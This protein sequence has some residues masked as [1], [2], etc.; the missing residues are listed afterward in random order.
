MANIIRIF[1][2]EADLSVKK[3][4][5]SLFSRMTFCWGGFSSC[6]QNLSSNFLS[7]DTINRAPLQG[8]DSFILEKIVPITFKVP[9][10]SNFNFQDGQS[11]LVLGEI[12]VLHQTIFSVIGVS[13]LDYLDKYLPNIGF[14]KPII[15]QLINSVKESDKKQFK[16]FLVDFFKPK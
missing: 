6:T 7:R 16:Q 13:Y 9:M 15:Y 14:S 12:S 11:L 8:F 10:S 4:A 3:L 2:V 1:D 5:F